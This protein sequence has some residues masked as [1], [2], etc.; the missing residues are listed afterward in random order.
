[1]LYATNVSD[2]AWNFICPILVEAGH[3]L[4][5]RKHS[6][7]QIIDA[8]FYVV[9][10]GTKWRNLPNDFPLWRTVYHYF[11]VWSLSGIWQSINNAVVEAVRMSTGREPSPSLVSLDSQSQTA[12]P[13]VKE[14]GLDGNKRVNG[15]KKHIAVDCLG[16]LL[17][18]YVT[19]ANTHD[20]VPGAWI[21]EDLNDLSNFPRLG[22]ILG[23]NAYKN[24]GSTQRVAVTVESQ[25][26]APGAKG[27]VPEAFRW[28]VERTLAWLNR[29]RRLVRN[30]EKKSVHQESMNYI[31]NTK[32][33]LRRL[34]KWWD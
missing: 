8:C 16:L 29:Q 19:A 25:E 17:L 30:Y 18:C 34:D 28:A 22:K 31:G 5:N 26:R 14:R 3:R 12:E 24:V 4:Q 13:G 21:V 1:M 6:L 15:R 27:F 11:R 7:R 2:A 10:N 20:S 9:D 33:C 32:I 23:D